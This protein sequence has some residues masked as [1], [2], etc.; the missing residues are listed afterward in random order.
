MKDTKKAFLWITRILK[1]KRIS[2]KILGGF[3]AR[4]YGVKRE[5][6]DIDIEVKDKDI[7]KLIQIVKPYI[8]FGPACRYKDKNWDLNLMTLKYMNQEIDICSKDALIF[9]KNTKHWEKLSSKPFTT[10]VVNIYGSDVKVETIKKLIA[11]KSKL[12]RKVDKEDVKQLLVVT[13]K[14]KNSRNLI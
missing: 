1:K 12:L 3:A 5:L 4:V 2:F 8:I 9:N 6:A 11:Y 10:N 7:I 14:I 13:N